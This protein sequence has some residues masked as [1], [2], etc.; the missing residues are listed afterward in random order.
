[1]KDAYAKIEKKGRLMNFP[2]LRLDSNGK[3]MIE[4][5]KAL[6]V[7]LALSCSIAMAGMPT[8]SCM[9]ASDY[10]YLAY[11]F[12]ENTK[13]TAD[14]QDIQTVPG[15]VVEQSKEGSLYRGALAYSES[16]E[17]RD[18]T[19][20]IRYVA[21]DGNIRIEDVRNRQKKTTVFKKTT[22]FRTREKK[23]CVIYPELFS[24]CI[25]DAKS[26][27]KDAKPPEQ[28][29]LGKEIIDGHPCMKYRIT[30]TSHDGQ[31][32]EEFVWEA[33]DLNHFPVR[34][35]THTS[36][37]LPSI[38]GLEPKSTPIT[39]TT[40]FRNIKLER[41][42]AALFLPSDLDFKWGTESEILSSVSRK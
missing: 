19:N 32:I 1:M 16:A 37:M 4:L 11:I 29:E 25:I 17:I 5:C 7:A 35:Q 10:E 22:I 31:K 26:G 12:R 36:T 15:G 2:F 6:C 21:L 34:R 23:A 38:Q 14:A 13:F 20:D 18:R 30:R 39:F 42:D 28:T 3:A 8:P 27:K 41:P 24:Y 9:D 40:I 33:T